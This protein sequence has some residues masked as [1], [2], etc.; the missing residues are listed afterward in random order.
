MP[1]VRDLKQFPA[2]ARGG[3][4]AIGNFDGVHLGH[5]RIV[6]RLLQRAREVGGS[7]II[8]TFDPHPVRL[9]RPEECPP[10]LTWTER[11]DMDT[12]NLITNGGS[13]ISTTFVPNLSQWE[14]EF[15]NLNPWDGNSN[16]QIK[17]EFSGENGNYLYLDNLRLQSQN[18]EMIDLQKS[19]KG[20]LVKIVDIL[21]REVSIFSKNKILFYIYENGYVEKKQI[22]Q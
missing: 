10:P 11:K 7:A 14:E 19:N 2:A 21:G 9:L 16:I 3:A 12:D 13:Y 22:I 20:D 4:I 5:L 6:R 15:V 8:F 17:F 1:I 18:S